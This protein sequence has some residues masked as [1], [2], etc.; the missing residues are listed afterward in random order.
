MTVSTTPSTSVAFIRYRRLERGWSAHLPTG[1]RIDFGVRATSRVESRDGKRVFRWLPE[2][3][4]DAH[5][6]EIRFYYRSSRLEGAS[7]AIP[8][9]LIE[10]IEYGPGPPPWGVKHVVFFR[11]EAR[12]DRLL[13][14]RPGFL[15]QLDE[16]LAS[17]DIAVAGAPVA[18]GA[19]VLSDP[20]GSEPNQ[21]VRSYHL[22]YKP[23]SHLSG[24][25]LLGS[26]VEIGRDGR[27]AL[28][29]VRF[30][31]ATGTT[32][33][34]VNAAAPGLRTVALSGHLSLN[35]PGVEIVDVNADALPDLVATSGTGN[36]SIEAYLNLGPR[37]GG[38]A[39]EMSGPIEMSGDPLSRDVTLASVETD[40]GFADFN[41][42]GRADLSY[43]SMSDRIYF[44]PNEG[45]ARWG[46]RRELGRG[47]ALPSRFS[48][49]ADVRQSDLDGDRRI[50]LV[51]SF[52]HGR[53]LRVWYCLAE[54]RY[55]KPVVW[56]CDAG[57]DLTE[58]VQLADV[59][60][61]QLTDLV[62]ITPRKSSSSRGSVSARLAI[63]APCRCPPVH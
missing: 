34:G 46:Q 47:R 2:R 8:Q 54:G 62:R 21:L 10:R 51:Q 24:V 3:Q 57:C 14:G 58:G 52:E 55:S 17:V 33:D 35:A 42:D 31:Y 43:R 41:G 1:E 63:N 45:D 44:F 61:D 25:S 7:D 32:S 56:R 5:G 60:G 39:P 50:D 49:R 23:T 36:R 9:R 6:N 15:V 29:A 37:H 30:E 38:G 28:P 12:P 11:Y 26:I 18:P 48:G 4:V 20:T 22:K 16:R 59:T 40:A 27:T 19:A 53:R 13:D